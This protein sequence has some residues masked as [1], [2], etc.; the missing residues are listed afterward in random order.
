MSHLMMNKISTSLFKNDVRKHE[1][2]LIHITSWIMF[3]SYFISFFYERFVWCVC[4]M[5]FIHSAC[6]SLPH[7]TACCLFV[8]KYISFQL[9]LSHYHSFLNNFPFCVSQPSKMNPTDWND[10]PKWSNNHLFY[11]YIIPTASLKVHSNEQYLNEM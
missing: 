6:F 1:L 8:C 7:C 5:F 3:D 2:N 9:S 10:D 11:T 4:Y